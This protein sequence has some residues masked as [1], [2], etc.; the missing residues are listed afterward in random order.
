MNIR[1][2]NRILFVFMLIVCFL[3]SGFL[4]NSF[5]NVQSRGASIYG[6]IY[7]DEVSH[8]TISGAK[9]TLLVDSI[10]EGVVY[11]D[12]NG[13]YSITY[14]YIVLQEI[15]CVLRVEKNGFHTVN[16]ISHIPKIFQP[17]TEEDIFLEP[18]IMNTIVNGYLKDY[19]NSRVLKNALVVLRRASDNQWLGSDE[20]SS[21]GWYT[22][23]T[24]TI[25]T[26]T[27]VKIASYSFPSLEDMP[28][29]EFS[30]AP[31]STNRKDL[32]CYPLYDYSGKTYVWD[33]FDEGAISISGFDFPID[34]GIVHNTRLTSVVADGTTTEDRIVITP[35][36]NFEH[37][38]NIIIPNAVERAMVSEVNTTIR[39]RKIISNEYL[40]GNTDLVAYGSETCVTNAEDSTQ[41][42]EEILSY[43]ALKAAGM[44][45]GAFNGIAKDVFE[46]ITGLAKDDSD[47]VYYSDDHDIDSR[48][49]ILHINNDYNDPLYPEAIIEP[50][51]LHGALSSKKTFEIFL[52]TNEN[53]CVYQLELTHTLTL[54][55]YYSTTFPNQF[56]HV[57]RTLSFTESM[58]F[59]YL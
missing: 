40:N 17:P 6:T 9:I 2:R 56:Y 16:W 15:V 21:T 22:I 48:S 27:Q 25:D 10:V 29:T 31:G 55:V 20:T 35:F 38:S 33:Y 4:T 19:E 3:T 47:P 41:E 42:Y 59:L 50:Q 57:V 46:M 58:T 39:C 8:P 49:I 23:T 18:A 32:N 43:L 30:I 11:S 45:I 54:H 1:R 36:L 14:P 5:S 44:V 34:W 12:A 53:D 51:K 13:D 24:N 28:G 37:L 52:D 26:N 7:S